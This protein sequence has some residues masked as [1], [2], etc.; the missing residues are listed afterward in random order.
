MRFT[1]LTAC[2]HDLLRDNATPP[3]PSDT[4]V[5][6]KLL[7]LLTKPTFIADLAKVREAYHH[8]FNRVCTFYLYPI[9]PEAKVLHEGKF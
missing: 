4:I 9:Q 3:V 8:I 2:H 6:Q 1:T 7:E 5:L